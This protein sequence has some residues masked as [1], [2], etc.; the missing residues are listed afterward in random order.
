M[1]LFGRLVVLPEFAGK[2]KSEQ[3]Q[4]RVSW[5]PLN[6]R[7]HHHVVTLGRKMKLKR[8]IDFYSKH[9]SL[10]LWKRCFEKLGLYNCDRSIIFVRLDLKNIPLDGNEPYR[11]IFATADDIQKERDYDDGWYQKKEAISRLREGHRLFVSKENGEMVY[12]LWA[13]FHDVRIRWLDL[14][15]DIPDDMIYCTGS[16][17]IPE[18][19]NRGIAH[20]LDAQIAQYFKKEGFRHIIGVVDPANMASRAVNKKLGIREYQMVRYKRY[21]FIKYYR[22]NKINSDK[23]KTFIA[24]FKSPGRLW[25]TFFEKAP[26]DGVH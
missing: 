1:R 8:V 14:C 6:V 22:V 17:T 18:Y 20:K 7:I 3:V 21:G 24:F 26:R 10:P 15:F 9:G 13:E 23:Q 2:T 11:F 16:H 25:E 19:R 12:C 5:K 4:C